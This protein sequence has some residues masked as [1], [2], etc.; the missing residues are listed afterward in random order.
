MCGSTVIRI[1]TNTIKHIFLEN[2]PSHIRMMQ[3]Q[4]NR[5]MEGLG[6][7]VAWNSLQLCCQSEITSKQQ[8]LDDSIIGSYLEQWS[9]QDWRLSLGCSS[10][11][12]GYP[13]SNVIPLVSEGY[14]TLWVVWGPTR[15]L[16]FKAL[17]AASPYSVFCI[18]FSQCHFSDGVVTGPDQLWSLVCVIAEDY[19]A[20][21]LS[22]L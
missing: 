4:H 1:T 20:V 12:G 18:S 14:Y 17:L 3:R 21:T 15:L 6:G 13:Y 19:N 7:R 16:G 5:T 9:T 10:V 22:R 11:G 2:L 8:K